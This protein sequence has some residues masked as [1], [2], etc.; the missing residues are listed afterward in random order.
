MD[1]AVAGLLGVAI[2]GVFGVAGSLLTQWGQARSDHQKW[3]RSRE[4]SLDRALR[5]AIAAFA[6][7]STRAVHRISWVAWEAT[8]SD[9]PGV[10]AAFAAY[11]RE[12]RDLWVELMGSAAVV[13]TLSAEVHERFLELIQEVES[14]DD[15]VANAGVLFRRGDPG[16]NAEIRS[17]WDREREVQGR[18]MST[19]TWRGPDVAAAEA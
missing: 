16:W 3:L 13:A 8:T 10:E 18:L 7:H 19:A 9:Q 11:D 12:M 6:H 15:Q 17:A 5:E 14:I 4:E 2:G 1:A